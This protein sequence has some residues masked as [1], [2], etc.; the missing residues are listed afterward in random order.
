MYIRQIR[1]NKALFSKQLFD[2]VMAAAL[3]GCDQKAVVR[4]GR[5]NYCRCAVAKKVD[6]DPKSISASQFT[7]SSNARK[8]VNI[9][10][11]GKLGPNDDYFQK[12]SGNMTLGELRSCFAK[13]T[14]EAFRT[15][16]NKAVDQVFKV[17]FGENV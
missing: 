14:A 5:W 15:K 8:A 3:R 10:G 1:D 9:E 6:L 11:S 4:S 2:Y 13:E 12:L 7:W 16:D 17:L